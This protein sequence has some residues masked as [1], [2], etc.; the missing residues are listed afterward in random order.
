MINNLTCA[1][2]EDKNFQKIVFLVKQFFNI[3][4]VSE[5]TKEFRDIRRLEWVLIA[6]RLLL[7]KISIM[8]KSQSAKLKGTLCNVPID[9]VDVCKTLPRPADSNRIV[10]VKLKRKLQYRCYVYFESV[11]PNV[12]MRLLQYLKLNTHCSMILR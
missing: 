1:R 5:L 4:E 6:R 7:R 2:H 10:I 12:I 11:R 9:A 3:L 8:P